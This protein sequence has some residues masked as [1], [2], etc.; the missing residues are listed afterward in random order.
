[1]NPSHLEKKLKKLDRHFNIRHHSRTDLAGDGLYYGN[2]FICTIPAG[3]IYPL[4]I[5]E[6]VGIIKT[7][8]H[9]SIQGL[10]RFLIREG[11]LTERHKAYLMRY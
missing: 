4:D 8:P 7:V 1:M 2:K 6:Y 9:R 11:V 3:H 5:K 10:V